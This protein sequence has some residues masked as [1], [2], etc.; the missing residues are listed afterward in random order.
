MFLFT[1]AFLL[2]FASIFSHGRFASIINYCYINQNKAFMLY[3]FE[4]QTAKFALLWYCVYVMYT[5]P[6]SIPERIYALL[7]F[8]VGNCCMGT[9]GALVRRIWTMPWCVKNIFLSNH[10]CMCWRKRFGINFNIFK[11]SFIFFYFG[12]CW[13]FMQLTL[14]L[15]ILN[16]LVGG[17]WSRF[18][19]CI[20]HFGQRPQNRLFYT[21]SL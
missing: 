19:L 13:L 21:A 2:L 17:M 10:P 20:M 11:R 16:L 15:A 4:I 18:L 7:G 6:Y 12:Y 1:C 3:I 9:W 8:S 14:L 5:C